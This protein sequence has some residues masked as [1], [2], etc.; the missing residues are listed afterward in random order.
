MKYTDEISLYP[1]IAKSFQKILK[2]RGFD[3]VVYYTYKEF[4]PKFKDMFSQ[5]ISILD[6]DARPDLIITYYNK[7][8]ELKKIAIEVKKNDLTLKD[9]AQAKIYCDV[10][11]TDDVFLISLKEVRDKFKRYYRHNK[12]ILVCANGKILKTLVLSNDGDLMYQN[13]FPQEE[14]ILNE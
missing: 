13:I 5:E 4:L 7:S 1:D 9:I 2:M 6:K 11:Q 8:K 10:F 14:D 3:S 12:D